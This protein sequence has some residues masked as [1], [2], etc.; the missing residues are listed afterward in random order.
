MVPDIQEIRTK[1]GHIGFWASIVYGHGIF[2]TVPP[3]ERHNY[4]AIRLSRYRRHDPY[5]FAN[6]SAPKKAEREAEND[7]VDAERK[8]IGEDKPS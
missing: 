7:R 6:P 1:I 2:M 4:L 8:W 3:S 5:V